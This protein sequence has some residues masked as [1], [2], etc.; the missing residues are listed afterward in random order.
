MTRV[1]IVGGGPGGYESALVAAQLGAEVVV[2]DS[3]GVGG[4]AVLTDCV[5]SKTLI[6]TAEVMTDLSEAGEL[7][8]LVDRPGVDLHRINQRVKSL[9]L[10][11]SA[12]I[13]GRLAREGVTVVRGRGRLDGPSRVAVACADGSEASYD[14]D[15]VLVATGAAPR[16]LP[17]AQPDGER[18]LTW[19]QV[20]DLDRTPEHMIVVGSGV[21]GAE[22]ASAYQSLGIPVTLVSSRDRV[23]PGED[24]DAAQVL[25]DV[26][27]RRGMTVLSRSR[28]Q[29]VTR[30]GDAVTVALVDGRQVEGSHCILALGSVPNTTGI[31]LEEAGVAL[32][33][34]GFVEVDR[35]SRTTAR[36]VY[37]AGDCTGVLMLASVAAM[38]GRIAM[39]HFLGDAVQ[40]LDLSEVSSNVFT[41]PEIATVGVTQQQVDAGRLA[42]DVVVQPLAT[43]ARAKM[44]GIHDGFVKLFVNPA[45]R[46]VL[47]GVVV[48]P[49]ASE[50]IHPL[51]I[52]VTERMTADQLAG[53]F[54]VYPSISGSIA[55][56]AR[57]LHQA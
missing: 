27:K 31:G 36:G 52:A 12:D 11:Q 50:L 17:T 7:G 2:V 25:E 16:T 14:A 22:F 53:T 45:S 55:E 49:R 41:S 46:S 51:A 47:G 4:S 44:Q 24:A 48:G 37:A 30:N 42:A 56:A 15:A 33:D 40:P 18:I 6:A 1:V 5:P 20:Y 8:I 57:R 29:S 32:T 23:L 34:G 38:Q 35:V 13:E 26:L 21:T 39:W 3:D 54:T 19:E 9:A 28:M 10:A 43:N